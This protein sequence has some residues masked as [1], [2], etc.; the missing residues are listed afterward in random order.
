VEGYKDRRK[1][2][3]RV[4]RGIEGWEHG[5]VEAWMGR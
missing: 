5:W 2:G 4:D 1:V 3:G